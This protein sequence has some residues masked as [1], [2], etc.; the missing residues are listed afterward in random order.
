MKKQMNYAN[1]KQIPWV[2]LAGKNEIEKNVLSI[3]NMLTGEQTEQS[4]EDFIQLIK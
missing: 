4:T 3:K 1:K 2:V